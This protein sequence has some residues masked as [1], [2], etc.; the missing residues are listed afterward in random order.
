[1]KKSGCKKALFWLAALPALVLCGSLASCLQ[2]VYGSGIQE[3]VPSTT[4]EDVKSPTFY[5]NSGSNILIVKLTD[6]AFKAASDLG[7]EQFLLDGSALPNDI[8]IIRDSDTQ[9]RIGL[10]SV[11]SGGSH[12][13]TVKAEA[14]ASRANRVSTETAASGWFAVDTDTVN[15]VLSNALIWS[16]AYGNGRFVAAGAGGR[17]AAY[18]AGT[19]T[20]VLPGT[21]A[22]QSGF[23]DTGTIRAVAYGNGKFVAAGYDA[24]MAFS[25]NGTDWTG[26]TESKFN[27]QSILAITYGNGKFVAAGD[28]GT[29]RYSSS[30]ESND[31]FNA[32]GT[33]GDTNFLGL[34]YGESANIRRFVAVG[35]GGKIAWSDDGITWTMVT[36][37]GFISEQVNA[38]AYGNKKFIAVGNDGKM[39]SSTDGK[40]WTALSTTELPNSVF[41]GK[42]ILN[43]C[44]GNG[45]FVAVG[46]NGKI[47][48]LEDGK[49]AW[50]AITSSPFSQHVDNDYGDEIRAIAYGGGMFIAGGNRYEYPYSNNTGYAVQTTAKMAYGY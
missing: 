14:L 42:G 39:A 20:A 19:W 24:R 35:T 26:W 49:A 10:T 6:G 40:S 4:P 48:E 25:A 17:M 31:W 33:S 34:T 21:S 2:T 45:K 27:G 43:V 29:I 47:A 12:R 22:G 3:Y 9:V 44:Y 32:Q 5:A 15:N 50:A 11:L 36:T 18:S 7:G 30:G 8:P 1:V 46:H 23:W 38:V 13:L 28:N 41:E 37:T 16:I